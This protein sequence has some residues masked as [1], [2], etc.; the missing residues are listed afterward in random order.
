[1]KVLETVWLCQQ[2]TGEKRVG[3]QIEED[4]REA[5]QIA[6]EVGMRW[7]LC[8]RGLRLIAA[9]NRMHIRNVAPLSDDGA[10]SET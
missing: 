8:G 9:A 5:M 2:I 7:L 4:S 10:K 6:T 1:M 3:K